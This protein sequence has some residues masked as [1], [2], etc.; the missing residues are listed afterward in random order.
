MVV[1]ECVKLIDKSTG[2][3]LQEHFELTNEV[4]KLKDREFKLEEAVAYLYRMLLNVDE[5]ICVDD[6]EWIDQT[7][8]DVK[9]RNEVR[10]TFDLELFDNI[11]YR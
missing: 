3:I 8:N 11:D 4:K 2:L 9:V 6:R 1:E 10:E 5:H 7:Y